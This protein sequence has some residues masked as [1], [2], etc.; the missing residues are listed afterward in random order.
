MEAADSFGRRWRSSKP[1]TAAEAAVILESGI[2]PPRRLALLS[3]PRG[4]SIAHREQG[5]DVRPRKVKR[6]NH[7]THDDATEIGG[8]R[9]RCQNA[10]ALVPAIESSGNV[11]M[12]AA[13]LTVSVRCSAGWMYQ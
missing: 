12:R 13:S 5:S 6:E 4:E 1:T 10:C 3:S 8:Q 9:S 2:E 7:L 11:W